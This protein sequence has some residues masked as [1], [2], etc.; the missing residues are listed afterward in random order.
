MDA[1][2]IKDTDSLGYYLR[3]MYEKH[4]EYSVV[5]RNGV[6]T[7]CIGH[8]R[9]VNRGVNVGPTETI[10]PD[11]GATSDMLR[12]RDFFAND[13]RKCQNV[14]VYMGDG[15]PTPVLGIGTARL[16]VEGRIIHLPNALHVLDLDCNLM[17]ITRHGM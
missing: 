5:D 15:S 2:N 9:S 8:C 1:H 3:L 14:F 17:S 4:S 16:E 6:P 13:Y 10:V 7:T 12:L 11:S